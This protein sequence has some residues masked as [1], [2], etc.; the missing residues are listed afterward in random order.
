M[1]GIRVTQELAAPPAEVWADVSDLASHVEWMADA[2]RI[3]FV[4]ERRS[5]VG[6]AFDC[7]T[8]VGPLRLN[9]RMEVTGW[10]EGTEI[11]IRHQG[12]VTGEGR[13]RLEPL[14]GG[15]TRFVWEERL[16]FPWWMGGP[17]GAVVGA[18]VLRWIWRRN[19]R[20][21]ARRFA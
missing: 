5:G 18:R 17:V 4:T 16:R 7:L 1:A 8:R 15:R 10:E 12:A 6:A 13:F 3:T 2:E 14:S 11:G 21:L 9:D 20:R 19:L